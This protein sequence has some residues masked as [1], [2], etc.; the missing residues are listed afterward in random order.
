MDIAIILL[1][2]AVLVAGILKVLIY[3]LQKSS[4]DKLNIETEM[5]NLTPNM[6]LNMANAKKIDS[7][8]GTQNSP[9]RNHGEGFYDGVLRELDCVRADEVPEKNI[10][11]IMSSRMEKN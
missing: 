11:R 4:R 2:S 5:I 10:L 1:I 7:M 9:V 6:A 3:V 8:M